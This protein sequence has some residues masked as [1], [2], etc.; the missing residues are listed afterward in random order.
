MIIWASSPSHSVSPR[1]LPPAARSNCIRPESR[2]SKE[3][4]LVDLKKA[5]K[6]TPTQAGKL[7]QCRKASQEWQ[8]RM[9]LP[10]LPNSE[11][12]GDAH[13]KVGLRKVDQTVARISKAKKDFWYEVVCLEVFE[14]TMLP[15]FYTIQEQKGRSFS[16]WRFELVYISTNQGGI[17]ESCPP[18]TY[19]FMRSSD[20]G[21][22]HVHE[23][24]RWYS[25]YGTSLCT[26]AAHRSNK[27]PSDHSRYERI[28]D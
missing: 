20:H 13:M 12:M 9:L 17:I 15:T 22:R 11:S 27:A 4:V 1:T 3:L 2:S 5:N 16:W 7:P 28:S 8:C 25:R 24:R 14:Y 21:R 26:S 18:R 10:H 19:I 23:F 6:S